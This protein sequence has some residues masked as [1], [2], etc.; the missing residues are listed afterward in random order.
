MKVVTLK[1][2]ILTQDLEQLPPAA[3]LAIN[4]KSADYV[5]ILCGSCLLYTSDAADE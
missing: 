4:L 5:A 2:L 3:A 1:G